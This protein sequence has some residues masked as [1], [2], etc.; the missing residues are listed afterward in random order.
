M[1]INL[2]SPPADAERSAAAAPALEG[3]QT[4]GVALVGSG[5]NDTV[6]SATQSGVPIAE[7]GGSSSTA[8]NVGEASAPSAA[9]AD[10][11]GANSNFPKKEEHLI[12]F[13]SMVT[14]TRIDY[15]L[16]KKGD[17]GLCKE[18][19]AI[20]SENIYTIQPKLLAMYV[21]IK[22]KK[23]K[24]AMYGQPRIKWNGL[25]EFKS[26]GDVGEVKGSGGLG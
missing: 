5:R 25:S 22:R 6:A 19:K 21:L 17:R 3:G 10:A 4:L 14:K 24:R 8:A 13:R 20:P 11:V 7:T 15:L 18:C 1:V 26:K 12:T 23:Q 9:A 2:D 16:F